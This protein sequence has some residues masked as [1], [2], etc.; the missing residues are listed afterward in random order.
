MRTATNIL[1]ASLLV[2]AVEASSYSL[3]NAYNKTNFF[4]NFDF[5]DSA[6]PTNGFVEYVSASEASGSGLAGYVNDMVYLGSDHT[7][8]NPTSGRSSTRLTSQL[9]WTKGLFLADIVHMPV[10]CGV[11]PAL[12]TLGPNWPAGGEIDIIEGVNSDQTDTITLHTSSGC[13][14]SD[15]GSLS[16][17]ALSSDTTTAD[18]SGSSGCGITT[19]STTAYGSGFNEQGGGIYAMEWTSEY[20]AVWFF[21]HSSEQGLALAAGE[22]PD[23]STFGTPTARFTGCDIDSYF[24]SHQIVINTDFCGDWAGSVWSTDTTCSALAST[25]DAYVQDNASAFTEAYWL[26]NSIQIFQQ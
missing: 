16:S 14:V 21:T 26:I 4:S 15:T 13:S 25:C 5:Y 10:G 7:T 20:I 11:W 17:S 19:T 6:D 12:W 1:A 23:V 18:C 9:S 8:D 22:T 24:N 3:V 2:A